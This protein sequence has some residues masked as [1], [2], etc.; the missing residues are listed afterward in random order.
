MSD[1][2]SLNEAR[3]QLHELGV[4]VSP[5]MKADEARELLSEVLTAS[6]KGDD[7][8]FDDMG[9]SPRG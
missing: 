2:I 5:T 4:S 8:N 7:D 6:S 9:A 1:E 3:H